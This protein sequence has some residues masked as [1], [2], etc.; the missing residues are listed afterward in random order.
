M[1]TLFIASQSSLGRIFLIKT[2]F[3][4]SSGTCSSSASCVCARTLAN[5]LEGR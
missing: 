3:G 5:V 1:V 4:V 2:G